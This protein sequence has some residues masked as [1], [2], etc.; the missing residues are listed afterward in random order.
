[1]DKDF[2]SK[3]KRKKIR[4]IVIVLLVVAFAVYF[5]M[6]MTIEKKGDKVLEPADGES[7]VTVSME[8]RCDNLAKDLSK[9]KKKEL[10]EYVPEDGVILAKTETQVP[11][12]SSAFDVLNKICREKDIQ[13]ES[14][15]TPTYKSY[16]VEGINYLYEFDAG[17]GSGWMYK[18]NEEFP[19]YGASEYEVKDGDYIVWVYTCDLGEDVGNNYE[20]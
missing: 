7:V 20:E 17:A 16:Y 3:I 6:D 9:L 5:V 4:N 13:V 11:E 1:M 12:G 2:E 18:V 19:Q 15:Y 10:E 14:S 8:I